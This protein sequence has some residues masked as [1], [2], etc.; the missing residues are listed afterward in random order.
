MKPVYTISRYRPTSNTATAGSLK[1]Y[2][3]GIEITTKNKENHA[4]S[5]LKSALLELEF[6]DLI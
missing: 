5:E 1:A 4:L 6:D 2:K 3:K